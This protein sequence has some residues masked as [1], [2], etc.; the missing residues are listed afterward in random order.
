MFMVLAFLLNSSRC[1]SLT[2]LSFWLG[3]LI[4][5]CSLSLIV[6]VDCWGFFGLDCFLILFFDVG[7]P[8]VL[9]LIRLFGSRYRASP[10]LRHGPQQ[11]RGVRPSTTAIT[12]A[13]DPFAPLCEI[14]C[15][16]NKKT[17]QIRHNV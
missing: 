17:K 12:R 5:V 10:C 16:K 3:T 13:S 7:F 6:V 9:S 8:V 2:L 4:D 15:N 14:P 11:W 1:S